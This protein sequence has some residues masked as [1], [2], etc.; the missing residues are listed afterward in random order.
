MGRLVDGLIKAG[1]A[2]LLVVAFLALVGMMG[3]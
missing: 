3:H 2:V 1:W